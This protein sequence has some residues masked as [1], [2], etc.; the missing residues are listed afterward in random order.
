TPV[1]GGAADVHPLLYYTTLDYWMELFGDSPA[2]VR[3][4]SALL[5]VACVLVVYGLS[6]EWFGVRAAFTAAL[7]TAV[8]P[9][10]VQ[11][12]QE[13]RMYMLLAL[14]LTLTTWVYWR[15]LRRGGWGSWLL[16][17]V[18]AGLSMYIQQLAAFFLMSLGLIPLWT[19]DRKQIIRTGLAAFGALLIYLPWL[20]YLPDQLGKLRQYWVQKPNILHFWLTLRSFISV[21]LDFSPAWWLPTFLLSAVLTVFLLVRAYRVLKRRVGS[22][23][24]REALRWV[25]WLAF[26]PMIFMWIASYLFQPMFLPRALLPS[27][28]LFYIALAWLFTCGKMPPLVVGSLG[29]VWAVVIVFGL[30]T[31]Y[32][33]D[34]FPTPPF[35][36]A[37]H[38]LSDEMQPGDVIVHA[39]KITALPMI[40]YDR[41]LPQRYVRDIPGSGSDTLA[42]PT[43]KSLRLLADDCAAVSANGAERVWFVTFKQ[44]EEE[45]EEL[46]EDE[47]DK[48]QYD[49]FAWFKNH[50]Q[51]MNKKAFH[52]LNIYLF[53]EP[54]DASLRAICD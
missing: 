42:V 46:V 43:Q 54:D 25:L 49:S 4:Y 38:Y 39:N 3:L 53:T 50:Y 24:E 15:A 27:A 5:G 37:D 13:T 23:A 30:V 31:H 47:P 48:A 1:E 6:R 32:T 17:A 11:Y 22:A 7:I 33:W 29:S 16:F 34:T 10:H 20:L 2:A 41:D 36:E 9:F 19:R 51:Q 8:A 45:M 44:L 12:S 28:V 21:N 40:Y 52:D 14:A 35:D 18:L 26:M